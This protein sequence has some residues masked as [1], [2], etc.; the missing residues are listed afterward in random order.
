MK[1]IVKQLGYCV[2]ATGLETHDDILY[3]SIGSS[4]AIFGN[5]G[6]ICRRI[7]ISP[8]SEI[9]ERGSVGLVMAMTDADGWIHLDVPKEDYDESLDNMHT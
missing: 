2:Q 5:R 7:S 6:N 3:V 8:D 9:C 4:S 1:I